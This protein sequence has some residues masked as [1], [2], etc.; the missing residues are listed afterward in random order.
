MDIIEAKM[1]K[2]NLSIVERDCGLL[3]EIGSL[4]IENDNFVHIDCG[5]CFMLGKLDLRSLHTGLTSLVPVQ[6]K[7]NLVPLSPK[8]TS[9]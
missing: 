9:I 5:A 8:P 3:G 1:K 2:K 4:L 6:V 7:L